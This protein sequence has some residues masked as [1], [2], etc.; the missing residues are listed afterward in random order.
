MLGSPNTTSQ[1]STM[2]EEIRIATA[3][4][5]TFLAIAAVLSLTCALS[6]NHGAAAPASAPAAAE[7]Y[8]WPI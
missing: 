1:E 3:F 6:L 2:K 8:G 5:A 7:V 4:R